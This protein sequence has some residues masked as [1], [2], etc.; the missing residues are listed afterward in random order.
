MQHPT[1]LLEDQRQMAEVKRILKPQL[2]RRDF[3]SR[4][5]DCQGLIIIPNG[6]IRQWD[7]GSLTFH[8]GVFVKDDIR[9]VPSGAK[10]IRNMLHQS[11]YL[12]ESG[13]DNHGNT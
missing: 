12:F 11:R 5:K 2:A 10:T 6:L 1:L 4:L 9:S 8:V 3:D 7:R 13:K